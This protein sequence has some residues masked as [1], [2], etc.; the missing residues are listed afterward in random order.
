VPK[1]DTNSDAEQP[2][3]RSSLFSFKLVPD[4]KREMICSLGVFIEATG[5][6]A[7]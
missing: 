4:G 5:L 2:P 3:I 1:L 7:P 6:M